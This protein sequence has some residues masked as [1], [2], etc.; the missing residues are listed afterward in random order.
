MT[1]G[2]SCDDNMKHKRERQ[3]ESLGKVRTVHCGQFAADEMKQ[4]SIG[5]GNMRTIEGKNT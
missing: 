2:N 1:Q 5:P 3:M 4:T